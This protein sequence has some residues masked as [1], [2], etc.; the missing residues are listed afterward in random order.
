MRL[1]LPLAPTAGRLRRVEPLARAGCSSRSQECGAVGPFALAARLPSALQA[2]LWAPQQLAPPVPTHCLLPLG[3]RHAAPSNPW[4]GSG[5]EART[6]LPAPSHIQGPA[7]GLMGEHGFWVHLDL[8]LSS[9]RDKLCD[10]GQFKPRF[11]HL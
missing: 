3:V 11:L 9:A 1:P 8:K 5:W 2:S 7:G 6:P 4:A 10:L